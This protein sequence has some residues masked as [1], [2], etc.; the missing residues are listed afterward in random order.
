MSA[1]RENGIDASFALIAVAADKDSQFAADCHGLSHELGKEAYTLFSQGKEITLSA[2]TSYCAYGFYHGFME[3]L[4]HATGDVSKA[5]EFCEYVGR[6]LANETTDGR[7]ACLHG[8]GHG[9]VED[10]PD[11]ASRGNPEAIIAP[12]L[13]LC[14]RVASGD[15]QDLFRC[16]SGV[17]NALEI[18]STS[19][20]Y[21]LSLNDKDPFWIC[22]DQP[23]QYKRACYTQ[24]LVAAMN[25]AH[26]NFAQTAGF[27]DKI[28]EDAYA[29]ETLAGLVVE[30]VHAGK[31]DY[32][33]TIALCRSLP[34]RLR[35]PCITGFGEGF[36]KYGPP[37]KEYARAVDFCG[38]D[39][40][41]DG[42][43]RSCFGRIL[44]ILRIW[45][46]AEK[47]KEICES[48]DLRYRGQGCNY[49]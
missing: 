30:R 42:E 24:F 41:T 12:S 26:G 22:R 21:G 14:E 34:F 39:L 4:L 3:A 23:D 27:I 40:L 37:G 13:N 35:M 6:T 33:E 1:L 44:S 7:G 38:S 29:E 31:I 16:A 36:L 49:F 19:G 2:K 45:Y 28:S 8:I 25:V 17:F 20:K 11:P 5:R 48:V 15:A 46:T 32:K 18:I 43:R 47:S 10:E 9:A